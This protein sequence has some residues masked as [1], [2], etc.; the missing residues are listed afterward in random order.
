MLQDHYSNTKAIEV[1][2]LVN[3]NLNPVYPQ[4]SCLA[5]LALVIPI[6]T[7]DCECAFS[8]MKRVKTRIRN[9][10]IS[11]TLDALLRISIE[12]PSLDE[13][14]FESAVNKWSSITNRKI[15]T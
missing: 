4:L 8:T 10:L 11:V 6:N 14:D 12:G 13:F 2:D 9:R 7:S 5:N 15:Q 1:E 3:E